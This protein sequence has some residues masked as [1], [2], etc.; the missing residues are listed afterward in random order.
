MAVKS[1]AVAVG[2]IEA[3]DKAL[4]IEEA[5]ALGIKSAGLVTILEPFK[6]ATGLVMMGSAVGTIVILPFTTEAR[7][8]PPPGNIVALAETADKA[9]GRA[10]LSMAGRAE[11]R[12]LG[13]LETKSARAV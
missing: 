2:V 5:T 4:E 13:K 3:E 1:N 12:A 7:I 8:P 6:K 10:D 9:S 11:A